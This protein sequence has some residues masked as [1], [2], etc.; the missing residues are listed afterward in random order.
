MPITAKPSVL[1]ASQPASHLPPT[2]L[3]SLPILW[4]R[5]VLSKVSGQFNK[6]ASGSCYYIG[7]ARLTR[8]HRWRLSWPVWSCGPTSGLCSS[9]SGSGESSELSKG[10]NQRSATCC[11]HRKAPTSCRIDSSLFASFQHSAGSRKFDN[12]TPDEPETQY[13][14]INHS[15]RYGRA[16]LSS[17]QPRDVLNRNPPPQ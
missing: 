10:S 8:D 15:A 3:H 2:Q 17:G 9:P 11:S 14:S 16:P 13:S 12:K 6:P 1:P 4:P 7:R 5:L